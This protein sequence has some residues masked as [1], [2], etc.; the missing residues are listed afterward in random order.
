[1]TEEDIFHYSLTKGSPSTSSGYNIYMQK[2][3]PKELT[4]K[5][6]IAFVK[7]FERTYGSWKGIAGRSFVSGVFAGL[8]ATV[9]VGIVLVLAG[10]LLEH[11]GVLPIVGAFFQ[12]LDQF[13]K[14]ALTR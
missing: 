8:G 10:Y 4:G 7:I 1:M 11:L 14:L 6:A 3:N 12:R 13:L 5:T 9:G 2:I